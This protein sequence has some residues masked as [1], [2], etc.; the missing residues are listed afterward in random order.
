[1][2]TKTKMSIRTT[3]YQVC[4]AAGAVKHHRRRSSMRNEHEKLSKTDDDYLVGSYL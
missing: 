4:L 2:V 1:M 3:P